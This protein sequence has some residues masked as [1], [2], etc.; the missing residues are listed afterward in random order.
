MGFGFKNQ[1]SGLGVFYIIFL[2]E[3]EE[4]SCRFAVYGFE[5]RFF[6]FSGSELKFFPIWRQADGF[7]IYLSEEMR[8]REIL[9]LCCFGPQGDNK[10]F[11]ESMDNFTDTFHPV[12]SILHFL[13]EGVFFW[14]QVTDDCFAVSLL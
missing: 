9:F 8:G 7:G 13:S 6:P 1:D 12:E 2:E 4:F 5:L 14:H 3:D 11:R 10:V